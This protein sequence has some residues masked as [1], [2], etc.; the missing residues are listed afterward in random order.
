MTRIN[1]NSPQQPVRAF[2]DCESVEAVSKSAVTAA[3]INQIKVPTSNTKPGLAGRQI[4]LLR[5][6][7]DLC[8]QI[9]SDWNLLDT[10]ELA[11]KIIDLENKVTVL[12]KGSPLD[13]AVEKIKKQAE[14]FHFRFVHPLA[15]EM[16]LVSEKAMPVPFAQTVYRAAKQIL[17]TNSLRAFNDLDRMQKREILRYAAGR[18]V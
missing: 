10:E 14:H 8:K 18:G 5:D 7:S 16:E 17:K 6:S 2:T 3:K 4:S 11:E 13:P 15:M 9:K 12:E 1:P